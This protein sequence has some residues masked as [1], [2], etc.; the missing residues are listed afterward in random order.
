MASRWELD[1]QVPRLWPWQ[2]WEKWWRMEGSVS[3]EWPFSAGSAFPEALASCLT[4]AYISLPRTG[5][6]A[7]SSWKVA[8]KMRADRVNWPSYSTWHTCGVV[9]RLACREHVSC[10]GV[11]Q[12]PADSVS[13][14][15]TLF[16]CPAH[17]GPS[18][19]LANLLSMQY[20]LV[21]SLK[22]WAF[23][24]CL[25]QLTRHWHRSSQEDLNNVTDP[26]LLSP[27][28]QV[29]RNEHIICHFNLQTIYL[30]S[31]VSPPF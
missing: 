1:L 7:T 18:W 12:E 3:W 5:S 15:A 6:R 16:A 17:L 24:P 8:R 29:V 20:V 27:A 9:A 13:H 10:C 31:L 28:S 22:R 11:T 26:L 23:S 21:G 25:C 30:F 19:A 14:S 2:E 4:C